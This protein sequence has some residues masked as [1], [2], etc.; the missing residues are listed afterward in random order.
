MTVS[1]VSTEL[2]RY[3]LE[4]IYSEVFDQDEVEDRFNIIAFCPNDPIIHVERK[5]DGSR[6]MMEYQ[7]RPR[8]Y[9]DFI[10]C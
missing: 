3:D 10:E 1:S 5:L 2:S 9:Y 6:G 4:L 7:D 8:Y